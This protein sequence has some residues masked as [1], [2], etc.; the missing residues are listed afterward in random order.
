MVVFLYLLYASRQILTPFLLAF[1]FAYMLDPLV[2]GLERCRLPRTAAIVSL[3][4]AVGSVV[5]L[6]VLL[7][8]PIIRLQAESLA[9]NLPGYLEQARQKLL[10]ILQ[11]LPGANK[12]DWRTFLAQVFERFG[13][14]PARLLQT[15]PG[16]ISSSFSGVVN[17]IFLIVN[18]LVVPIATFYFLR[19]F[20]VMKGR[21]LAYLPVRYRTVVEQRFLEID[22][23]LSNFV[24]GQLIVALMLASIYSVGLVLAGTPMGVM[25]GLFAGALSFIPYLGLIFGLGPAL[26]LTLLQFQD[27][28]HPLAV[29]VVFAV[30]QFI[31]GNFITP[32]VVGSQVGLHP[33]AV[34]I[35][36][37][38]G[39]NFFG[40]MGILLAVPVAAVLRVLLDAWLLPGSTPPTFSGSGGDSG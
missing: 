39:G 3:M 6:A 17:A 13:S 31:E 36:V 12:V 23:V 33:V 16:L 9:A 10:P 35:A 5:F 30:A 27:W 2:R 19:D 15:I 28:Q 20:S 11:E 8:G 4:F 29:L 1:F 24:R 7:L 34:M 25:V 14:L 40:V 38:I 21:L 32:R 37:L 18:L 26:L 22:R